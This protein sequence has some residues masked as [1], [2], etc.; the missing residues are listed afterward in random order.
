MKGSIKLLTLFGLDIKIHVTFLI[1]PI[2]FGFVYTAH[3]G[4]VAGL[5]AVLFIGFVFTCVTF[6]E[7][8]HSLVAKANKIK[9]TGI[10]LLPIG[11]VASM[12]SIP[13]KPS[14][15]FAI[16]IAGPLFNISLA[17]ILF[18]PIYLL[19]GHENFMHPSLAT[20]SRT[21]SYAFWINIILAAFNL[22]P[23]FPM[24]GGRILRAILARRMEY[25][26]A[27]EIAVNFG[28]IFAILFGFIGLT[29]SPPNIILVVIAI[30]IYM[31]ASSEEVQVDI[32]ETIRS[33]RAED[34][35]PPKFAT[36]RRDFPIS[37]VL[38]LI[39]HTHQEDFPVT[40]DGDLVGF[41]TRTDVVKAVHQ[42]G[43]N[44]PAGDV[45]RKSFP[46]ARP[47]DSLLKVQKLMSEN[48]IKAIPVVEKEVLRGV[49]TIEDIT[50][51]YSMLSLRR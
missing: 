5:R 19:V 43:M 23:A 15:E 33:F 49:I 34:V 24:D 36:I 25:R 48:K 27:T 9:V 37:K 35:L 14:Q 38:E 10:T 30:F 40:E 22:L 8:C 20:W 16:S 44:K 17:A 51:V 1:L 4:I 47:K 41:L 32:R 12:G 6:H 3:M 21:L 42:F 7:V 28:H 29:S 2:L 50:R 26:R 13:E 11:G 18:L 39:F 31:A 45:M 46:R